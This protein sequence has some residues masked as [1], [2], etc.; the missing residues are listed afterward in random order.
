[1]S[2]ATGQSYCL[3]V[4]ARDG[5]LSTL[6]HSC[7]A[8][9]LVST[10]RYKPFLALAIFAPSIAQSDYGMH[11]EICI[12]HTYIYT[13]YIYIHIHNIILTYHIYIYIYIY[14]TDKKKHFANT[15]L[16]CHHISIIINNISYWHFILILVFCG[17]FQH[18]HYYKCL[19][20]LSFSCTLIQ[21]YEDLLFFSHPYDI[22][23][24]E[25][26]VAFTYWIHLLVW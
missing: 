15:I 14:K 26:Q 22:L 8:G 12:I 25:R 13:I 6:C 7:R 1:M 24:N 23:H 16:I 21:I 11:W 10:G 19:T 3:M 9:L 2:I 4:I 17:Y 20:V 5:G 18:H